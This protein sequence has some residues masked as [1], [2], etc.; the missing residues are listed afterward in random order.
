MLI[1]RPKAVPKTANKSN[2]DNVPPMILGI[3]I[4]RK[5][6]SVTGLIIHARKYATMKGRNNG[7][8]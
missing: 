1:R 5:S 4:F 3:F 6:V 8:K 2:K 7:N